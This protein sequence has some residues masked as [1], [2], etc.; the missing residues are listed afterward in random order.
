MQIRRYQGR[1]LRDALRRAR[2]AQGDDAFVLSHESSPAGGV[3]VAIAQGPRRRVVPAPLPAAR[4]RETL[5]EPGLADLEQ[6]LLRNGASRAFADGLMR[7]IAK[8]NVRG[9]YVLDAAV[10]SIEGAF[11]IAPSPAPGAAPLAFGFLGPSGSGKTLTLAKLAG[12]LHRAGRRVLPITLDDARAGRAALRRGLAPFGLR[13]R[14]ARDS[15]ELLELV[16]RAPRGAITLVDTASTP[17]RGHTPL[18]ELSRLGVA[19][20][21]W[22]VAA[23]DCAASELASWLQRFRGLRPKA[24]VVTKLDATSRPAT[25]VEAMARRGLPLAFFS[26]APSSERGLHRAT[27]EHI[28]DLLLRGRLGARKQ[29]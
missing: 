17:D 8:L 18:R 7:R 23:A 2:R 25:I 27:S 16:R 1:D 28:A 19:V 24:G 15:E 11:K 14:V 20:E 26:T 13:P 29:R 4:R 6:R 5:R 21:P 9:M 12:R 22:I 10:E 3:T